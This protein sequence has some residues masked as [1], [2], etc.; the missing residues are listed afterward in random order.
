MTSKQYWVSVGP[1]SVGPRKPE[2]EQHCFMCTPYESQ[3]LYLDLLYEMQ[4]TVLYDGG[5]QSKTQARQQK[6]QARFAGSALLRAP[7][8]SL[9]ALRG[10]CGEISRRA[11]GAASFTDGYKV[12]IGVPLSGAFFST[13]ISHVKAVETFRCNTLLTLSPSDSIKK[14]PRRETSVEPTGRLKHCVFCCLGDL[15]SQTMAY[16]YWFGQ[17]LEKGILDVQFDKKLILQLF[18]STFNL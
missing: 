11:V 9:R 18:L 10:V 14:I 2:T 15:P 7:P 3:L 12:S 5:D 1:G 16:L 8:R 13:S 4:E 17:V 6:R